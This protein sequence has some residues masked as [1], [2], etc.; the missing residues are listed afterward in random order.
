KEKIAAEG[1]WSKAYAVINL[2][3]DDD[4]EIPKMRVPTCQLQHGFSAD[5]LTVTPYNPHLVELQQEAEAFA[6]D[7]GINILATCTPYQVGNLP[8]RGEHIAWMESSAVVYANS[9]IGAKSN[10]E[11]TASTGA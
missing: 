5:A 2:D 6:S 7:K 10:C 9:V 1:G 8:V 11:G 4:I 3:C